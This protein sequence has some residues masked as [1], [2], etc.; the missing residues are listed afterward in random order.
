M[1]KGWEPQPGEMGLPHVPELA[2]RDHLSVSALLF[3]TFWEFYPD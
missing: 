1:K 2:M 3:Y